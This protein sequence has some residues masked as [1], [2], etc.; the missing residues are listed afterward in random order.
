MNMPVVRA[1]L[2]AV[3]ERVRSVLGAALGV[4]LT[5]A[6]S[7]WLSHDAAVWLVAPVGASAVLVFTAPA[8]PLA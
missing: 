2:P 5:A 4:L 3:S 7:L 6:L 8:S 1:R